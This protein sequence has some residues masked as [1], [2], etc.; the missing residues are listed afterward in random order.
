[1]FSQIKD[2]VGE[3]YDLLYEY[4]EKYINHPN[5]DKDSFIIQFSKEL[6][7]GF[8][9]ESNLGH[10]QWRWID[11]KFITNQM[12]SELSST[13]ITFKVRDANGKIIESEL[14]KMIASLIYYVNHY[15]SNAR[16][17][18]G[19]SIRKKT[20]CALVMSPYEFLESDYIIG[21]S[22]SGISYK[23]MSQVA[24]ELY[25]SVK[26][27]K[28]SYNFYLTYNNLNSQV[29]KI[30]SYLLQGANNDKM[31]SSYEQY[32]HKIAKFTRGHEIIQ[33]LGYKSWA[34]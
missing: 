9:S 18:E 17:L 26:P 12:K 10:S 31:R 3:S 11:K 1:M 5:F 20:T 7:H 24:I 16:V 34:I 30:S 19:D 29:D 28:S 8:S 6:H 13:S 2:N 14:E 21:T 23:E 33:N 25:F 15:D 32:F 27:I 4:F 22:D